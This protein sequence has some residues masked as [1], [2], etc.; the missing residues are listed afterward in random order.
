MR[1][2]IGALAGLVFL[3][4]GWASFGLASSPP[5]PDAPA[6]EWVSWLSSNT[7][8]IRATAVVGA[9]AVA[10]LIVW[11]GAMR[12]RVSGGGGPSAPLTVATIGMAVMAVSFLTGYG[13][14][15]ALAMRVAE[16][17]PDVVIFGVVLSGVMSGAGQA[18]LCAVMGG[19]TLEAHQRGSLPRWMMVVGWIGAAVA[20]LTTAGMGIDSEGIM[21][22]VLVGWVLTS[23]WILGGVIL[24]FSRSGSSDVGVQGAPTPKASAL[25]T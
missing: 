5:A 22:L 6:G 13:I 4:G 15:S 1:S 20:L 25:G 16:L 8:G 12:D 11:F 3:V 7:G 24:L 21:A 9:V 19:V 2:R 23:V 10:A 18:G 14:N 17:G